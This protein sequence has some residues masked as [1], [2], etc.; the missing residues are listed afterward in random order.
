MKLEIILKGKLSIEIFQFTVNFLICF[1]I[2][3]LP[4]LI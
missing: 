2:I 1:Y 4:Q 3:E